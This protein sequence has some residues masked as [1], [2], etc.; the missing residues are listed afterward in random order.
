[1]NF[2]NVRKFLDIDSDHN[3]KQQD[4]EEAE[5]DVCLSFTKRGQNTITNIKIKVLDGRVYE[6][7]YFE[8]VNDADIANESVVE[9]RAGDLKVLQILVKYAMPSMLGWNGANDPKVAGMFLK[10]DSY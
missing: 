6:F 8:I 1:L 4:E 7:T 3:L 9:I 5:E 10:K 2:N